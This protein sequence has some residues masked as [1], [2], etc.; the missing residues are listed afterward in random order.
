MPKK[1][2]GSYYSRRI[3]KE[4]N[5]VFWFDAMPRFSQIPNFELLCKP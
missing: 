1:Y 5:E 2:F 4:A 3:N